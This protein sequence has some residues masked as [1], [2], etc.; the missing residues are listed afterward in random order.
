MVWGEYIIYAMAS[1]RFQQTMLNPM[2]IILSYHIMEMEIVAY[3]H[4][5]LLYIARKYKLTHYSGNFKQKK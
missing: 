1:C 3:Q 2:I 5:K 4:L